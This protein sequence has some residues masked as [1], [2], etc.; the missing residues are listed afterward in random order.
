MDNILYANNDY[1][2]MLDRGNKHIFD[3]NFEYYKKLE[4]KRGVA[5]R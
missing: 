5:L 1:I 3:Y 4:K 2:G